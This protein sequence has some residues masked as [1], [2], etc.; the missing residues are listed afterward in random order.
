MIKAFFVEDAVDEATYLNLMDAIESR[1]LLSHIYKIEMFDLI[2]PKLNEYAK[3]IQ[4]TC[5]AIESNTI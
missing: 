1:N 5:N 3:A 2:Y 4:H